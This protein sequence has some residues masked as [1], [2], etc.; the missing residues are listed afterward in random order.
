MAENETGIYN[1]ALNAIGARSNV[2]SSTE[3][4]RE[5]E[6]CRLW[7]TSV[8][9]QVLAGAVWPE[10]TKLAYL[11][12]LNDNTGSAD[13][14]PA[15]ARPGYEFAYAYPADCVRP[16]YLTDFSRFLV[17]QYGSTQ[18]GI[19]TSTEKAILTYTVR[20]ED[21]TQWSPDLKM[22]IVYGLAANICMPLSAKPARARMLADHA[23]QI[24]LVA[25][26]NAANTSNDT[27]ESIPD[28]ISQRGYSGTLAVNKYFHPYGGL[29]TA[30]AGV[31]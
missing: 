5:A 30:G 6:V 9:D 18:R 31:N 10:A 8:R 7:Y 16:Q 2:A 1:L 22:A 12:V 13:W 20:L 28:W 21:V 19:M 17:T 14:V 29:L 15:N 4:S 24:L 23:N 27:Y 3:V 11:A 26:E 25:R